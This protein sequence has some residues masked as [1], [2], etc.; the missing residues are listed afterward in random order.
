LFLS[1]DVPAAMKELCEAAA[2][3][4]KA[5]GTLSLPFAAASSF[6]ASIS[7]SAA[8]S[9]DA[10]HSIIHN[11]F[12]VSSV[13]PAFS[14]PLFSPTTQRLNIG[15]GQW[16]VSVV[17]PRSVARVLHVCEASVCAGTSGCCAAR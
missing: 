6:A 3:W 15:Q 2:K 7:A 8:A 17:A 5:A 12:S 9:I 16:T 14:P 13:P 1:D 4:L 10:F 11:C